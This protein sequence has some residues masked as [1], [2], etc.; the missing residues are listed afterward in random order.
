M[1]DPRAPQIRDTSLLVRVG[2][3]ILAGACL[4]CAQRSRLVAATT[5]P[6]DHPY[7]ATVCFRAVS[8]EPGGT[9]ESVTVRKRHT[10]CTIEARVETPGRGAEHHTEEIT[11]EEFARTWAIVVADRLA[12]FQPEPVEGRAVDFGQVALEL[13]WQDAA[14]TPEHRHEAAWGTPISNAQTLTPFLKELSALSTR[15]AGGIQLSLFPP[16]R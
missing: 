5:R 1:R 16:G 9:R 6:A 12:E 8:G 14:D 4:T 15:H 11:H 2:L 7:N 10:L 3:F 13:S